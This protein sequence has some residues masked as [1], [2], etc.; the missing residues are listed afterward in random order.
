MD[1]WKSVSFSK[2]EE[3]GITAEVEEVCEGEIFQRTLAGRL[4]TDNS[5]NSKAFT[6]TMVGAWKL[7]N[8]IEVQELNKN[9]FL[10]RFATRRDL[11]NILK[12]GPWSFDRNLLVLSRITGEEQHPDLN[13]HYG[14][15]WVRIYELPLMLRSE[16]MAKKLGGILGEFEELDTKEAH[17]NGIFLRIKVTIDLKK[18]LKRGTVVKLKEKNLRVHFKYERLPTFCFVCGKLGHQIKDCET[19]GDLSD[20]GFEENEEQDLA[21]GA[22]LR[23]SPLP[24]IQEEAKRKDSTSSSCSKN[25]SNVSSSHSRCEERGRSKDIEEGEV[26]QLQVKDQMEKGEGTNTNRE[27]GKELMIKGSNS[28]QK[29]KG[30]GK[31]L[32]EIEAMAESL[33]ER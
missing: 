25:L 26:E 23:A 18:S 7:K 3:E 28:N 32:L 20:E 17:R 15:F 33:L 21:F 13:M 29:G 30:V 8:P 2:E 16:A 22:W 19:V 10:F 5:F 1:K 11:E 24:R 31:A 14:T 9:L 12:N 6:N 4:W 27:S